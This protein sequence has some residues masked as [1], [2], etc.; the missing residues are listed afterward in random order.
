M[1]RCYAITSSTCARHDKP[2]HTE[3]NVRLD[4]AC[5]GILPDVRVID[6]VSAPVSSIARVHSTGYLNWLQSLC[7]NTTRVRYIDADTYVTPQ[8]FE[9]AREAAGAAIMAVDYALRGEPCFSLMRP[10]G[11]HAEHERAMGFCLLNNVAIGVAH[12]LETVDRVA[13]VDWDVHHGNGTEHCFYGTDR[14]LYCSVHEEDIFPYS[15]APQETGYGN[16]DGYTIN[17]P[18]AAGC[19]GAD[20]SQVFSRIFVPAIMRF[21]PD[22]LV[23]SAG[24][25]ILF[26]DHLG[27]MAVKP[28]DFFYLTQILRNSVKTPLALVLEGGYSPSQGLAIGYIFRALTEENVL[29]HPIP[30]EPRASTTETIALLRKIHSLK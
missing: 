20:Y 19:T 14:V 22:L 30:G 2:N 10:P 21:E 24:Q 3:S 13:I 29:M 7:E 26:D 9:V 12:A 18:L 23:I 1:S 11:H 5:D 28:Q 6:P 25:D 17:A 16:G 27:S 8:S 4:I 15:G